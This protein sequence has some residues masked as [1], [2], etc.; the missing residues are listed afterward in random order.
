MGL[1]PYGVI[2]KSHGFGGEVRLLPYS[3]DFSNLDFIKSVYIK[4][5]NSADF[6]KYDILGCSVS[7]KYAIL[8]LEGIENF[9]QAEQLKGKEVCIETSRLSSSEEDDFY[10]FE[11]VGLCVIDTKNNLI[12]KVIRLND[13]GLQNILEVE[14]ANGKEVLIPFVEPII[15]EVDIEKKR[16]VVDPPAGLLEL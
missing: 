10:F 11:L 5:G 12:G 13:A 2:S 14:M 15:K 4:T 9:E 8:Q 7:G 3:R 16:I 6:K 1:F